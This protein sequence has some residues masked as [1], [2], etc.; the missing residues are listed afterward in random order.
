[1]ANSLEFRYRH[2]SGVMAWKS[3][4]STSAGEIERTLAD[5]RKTLRAG[6]ACG[7]HVR[8]LAAHCDLETGRSLIIAPP[9]R[10][11]AFDALRDALN[12]EQG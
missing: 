11:W 2:R 9:T 10:H 6:L 4:D 7:A 3:K 12:H 1:M 5:L 8:I